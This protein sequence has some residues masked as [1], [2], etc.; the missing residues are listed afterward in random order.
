M[1]SAAVWPQDFPSK[2]VRYVVPF[3]PGGSPDIVGRLIADRLTRLW[4][5]QVIVE[6][7]AGVAGVLGSA[8]VAK[9]PPDGY[10][11]LQCNIAPNAI[12]VSMFKKMPYDQLRDFAPITQIGSL[13]N[14][15]LSHPSLPVGSVKELIA[16]AKA[17][18]GKLSYSSGQVGTSPQLSIELL[19]QAVEIDMVNIPYKIGSQ[20]L[21][22]AI[23][24]Q[25]PLNVSN[26]PQSI[27]PV[28]SGRLRGL[29]VTSAKRAAPLPSV[30]TMQ[31]SGVA[32]YEV[33]SWYGVCAP[34][35]T[36]A[37]VLD[38]VNADVA[39]ILRIPEL[40]QRLSELITEITPTSR[41]E[42]DRF[43]RAEISRWAKVIKDAHI[44]Q[45]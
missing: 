18:P 16:Y 12:G 29:A 11:L 37:A 14:I 41:D 42:F 3:G 9:S 7:R 26:L 39:S 13:P 4:G 38:K 20:G 25:V 8:F 43:I 35:G 1:Y 5:Q 33:T 23:G 40:Q 34:A 31:E 6:N 15:L 36:P 30:P 17:R 27:A 28:Q 2:P 22:D 21:T 44:P 32:G 45:I 10:T 19:K 24:G